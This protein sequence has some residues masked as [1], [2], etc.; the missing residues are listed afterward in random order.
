MGSLSKKIAYLKETIAILRQ[1]LTEITNV[2]FTD[3]R[4]LRTVADDVK[5]IDVYQSPWSVNK[6]RGSSGTD[7]LGDY[8]IE[9]SDMLVGQIGHISTTAG[10]WKLAVAYPGT[11]LFPAY[12][13]EDGLLYNTLP[14]FDLSE[15]R[16]LHDSHIQ[17]ICKSYLIPNCRRLILPDRVDHTKNLPSLFGNLACIPEG[18]YLPRAGSIKS[19][20]ISESNSVA[21]DETKGHKI[22]APP[23]AELEYYLQVA[24]LSADT[25]V[26]IFNN[27]KDFSGDSER[28]LTLGSANIAKLTEDQKNIAYM[29]GWVLK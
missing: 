24:T 8:V 9:S 19:S 17:S 21:K 26:A 10:Y 14:A 28:T 22:V 15:G 7:V 11:L 6:T 23:N 27:L 16:Y 20:W 3:K 29:K 12:G 2:N 25:M 5:K 13:K 4:S 18:V 1:N